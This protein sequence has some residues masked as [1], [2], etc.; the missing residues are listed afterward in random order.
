[1]D[2]LQEVFECISKDLM[3][4]QASVNDLGKQIHKLYTR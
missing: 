4:V 3:Q 1:M 2:M